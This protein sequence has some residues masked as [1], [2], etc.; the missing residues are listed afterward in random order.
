MWKKVPT[1]FLLE[2]EGERC[3]RGF[4]MLNNKGGKI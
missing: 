2:V 4:V 3:D 1:Q